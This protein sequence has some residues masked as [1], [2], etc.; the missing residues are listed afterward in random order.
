M[1]CIIAL[2]VCGI[3]GIFSLKYRIIAKEAFDCVFRRL[4]FRKCTSGLD[5]RLKAQITGN[6]MKR[7]PKIATATYKHFEIISWFFTVL[8]I[9]SLIW[10]GYGAYN[11]IVYGNCNGEDSTEFCVFNGLAGHKEIVEQAT[12][13][14]CINTQECILTG[15]CKDEKSCECKEGVCISKQ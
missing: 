8:L 13:C 2:V 4:T 11:F 10:T 9:A 5:A 3:L 12:S 14:G 15:F 1:I 7:S 6:L